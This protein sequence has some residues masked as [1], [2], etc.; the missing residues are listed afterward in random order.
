MTETEPRGEVHAGKPNHEFCVDPSGVQVK[1][2][3]AANLPK[4]FSLLR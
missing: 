2:G 3:K 4:V 1:G